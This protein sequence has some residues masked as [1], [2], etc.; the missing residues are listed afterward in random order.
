L[1]SV[2]EQ[3]T[4]DGATG[5]LTIVVT[6]PQHRLTKV[7]FKNKSGSAAEEGSWTEDASPPY[8]Y[9]VD[10]DVKHPSHIRYK[11]TFYDDFGNETA[12]ERT[13]P[14]GLAV[15][16]AKPVVTLNMDDSGNVTAHIEGDQDTN[17][18]RAKGSTSAYPNEAAVD[19]ET[20]ISGSSVDTGTL[21][22]LAQGETA[23]VSVRAYTAGEVG[24]VLAKA[25]LT[26][27][28]P[29]VGGTPSA[30]TLVVLTATV[31][32]TRMVE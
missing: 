27:V 14:F 8:S 26:A 29:E 18:V 28:P 30:P 23:Y 17:K 2:D 7:E 3:P 6:D 31:E 9:T 19:A 25:Q 24:S 5:T 15:K 1:P 10:L 21:V 32:T 12:K 20:P 4:D 22:T 16:P 13:V 11:I